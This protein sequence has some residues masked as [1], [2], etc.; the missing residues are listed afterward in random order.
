MLLRWG[1]KLID[2]S[3]LLPWQAEQLWFR[4]A[5]KVWW[6]WWC[7][8]PS[9]SL[10]APPPHLRPRLCMK[11]PPAMSCQ[12]RLKSV[13]TNELA[14]ITINNEHAKYDKFVRKLD[15]TCSMCTNM[16][17]ARL[18]S[19]CFLPFFFKKLTKF[20]KK[21]GHMSKIFS[22]NKHVIKGWDICEKARGGTTSAQGGYARGNLG[23]WLAWSQGG[24]MAW[25]GCWGPYEHGH[26]STCIWWVHMHKLGGHMSIC[27]WLHGCIGLGWQRML[28]RMHKYN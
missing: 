2:S 11:H 3:K 15:R 26:G 8:P 19:H 16:V 21:I 7:S 28:S 14:K 1:S 25:C 18:L 13:E 20:L 5:R 9:T 12:L 23:R 17:M 22:Q 27:I 6:E 4:R 10:T 24:D